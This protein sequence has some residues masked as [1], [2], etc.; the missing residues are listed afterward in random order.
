MMVGYAEHLE[1]R[2]QVRSDEL[3]GPRIFLSG[4]AFDMNSATSY[5]TVDAMIMSQKEAG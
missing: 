2:E 1:M 5:E 3:P 4:P